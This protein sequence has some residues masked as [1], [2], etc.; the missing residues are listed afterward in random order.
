M[1]T[2]IFKCYKM[3]QQ[4]Q[5]SAFVQENPQPC[6]APTLVLDASEVDNAVLSR[7]I[8]EVQTEKENHLHAYN[9]QHN[10]HNRGR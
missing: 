8:G 3:E 2:F 5:L 7:L 1:G 6:A 9:R 10:R 4:A